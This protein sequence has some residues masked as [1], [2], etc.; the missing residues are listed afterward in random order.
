MPVNPV[1]AGFD[2]YALP[3]EQAPEATE[4]DYESMS[5]AMNFVIEQEMAALLKQGGSKS[6]VDFV[7]GRMIQYRDQLIKDCKQAKCSFDAILAKTETFVNDL[8]KI[9]KDA[10]A[11]YRE[12]HKTQGECQGN[13]RVV[14]ARIHN[15]A[16]VQLPQP[17]EIPPA[18]LCPER[19]CVFPS[20]EILQAQL[21]AHRF[22]KDNAALLGSDAIRKIAALFAEKEIPAKWGP[23]PCR[24]AVS[25]ASRAMVELLG[26]RSMPKQWRIDL[27]LALE[28][29]MIKP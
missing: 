2:M 27:A 5:D 18:K 9:S 19:R 13:Y 1:A 17:E 23:N 14:A 26:G 12:F 11:E 3:V 29:C 22:I 16:Q 6:Q 7:K 24:G 25:I 10:R 20:Q 8:M 28:E 4:S 15:R 21:E